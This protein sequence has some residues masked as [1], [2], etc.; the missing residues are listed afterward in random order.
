MGPS[1]GVADG[2]R[3][4]FP[5]E[6]ALL[7][8][9]CYVQNRQEYRAYHLLSSGGEAKERRAGVKADRGARR[10]EISPRHP[11]RIGGCPP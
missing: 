11:L 3:N 6:N 10:G 8:A 2:R 1:V 9:Q 7:L 4:G 5:Q